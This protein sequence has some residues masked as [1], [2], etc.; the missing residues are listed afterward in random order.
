MH[1]ILHA[2]MGVVF[3]VAA[4]LG[5]AFFSAGVVWNAVRAEPSSVN[6]PGLALHVAPIVDVGASPTFSLTARSWPGRA[7][8]SIRFVSP[9]H[10]FTGS[11]LWDVRCRCFR[12]AVPLRKGVH[13]L[14]LAHAYATARFSSGTASAFTAFQIR[15]LAPGGR[16]YAP[17]GKPILRSWVS[18]PAPRRGQEQ[19]FCAWV[20]ASDAFGMPGIRVRF[21]VHYSPKPQTLSGLKTDVNGVACAHRSIDSAPVGTVVRV[22]VYAGSLH[23]RTQFRPRT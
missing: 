6:V 8:A 13:P 5:L 1:G 7:T 16:R 10:G 11:M 9:H 14:E 23:T 3:R 12:L 4:A 17:G 19:H 20:H 22:D 2:A 18:D 21:V 15:G